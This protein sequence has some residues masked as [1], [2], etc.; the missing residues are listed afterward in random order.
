[1]IN[2]QLQ[3]RKVIIKAVLD[4]FREFPLE[5]ISWTYSSKKPSEYLACKLDR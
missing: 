5:A 3:Q 1:M 4:A 2:R